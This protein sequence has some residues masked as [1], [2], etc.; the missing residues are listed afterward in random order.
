MS[1]KRKNIIYVL[2][3]LFMIQFIS[4]TSF[5]R[6]I[7]NGS[8][9]GYEEGDGTGEAPSSLASTS[10]EGFIEIGGG[11]YLET[12]EHI[13]NLSAMLESGAEQSNA[14]AGK[15]DIVN[16]ALA[17]IDNAVDSY[18]RLIE[19]AENTP[20]NLAV[21][22]KLKE[23]PYETFMTANGLND[24]TFGKVESYLKDGNITGS[25]KY[26]RSLLLEIKNKIIS[27]KDKLVQTGDINSFDLLELN[28]TLSE[29]SIFGNYIARVFY[30][31]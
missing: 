1:A 22:D 2:A 10:I 30:T 3:F 14:A 4:T 24:V 11:Y 28:E 17:S 23:F 25:Y 21:N 12:R 26:S 6:I 27:L 9:T 18:D 19:K 31:L 5:A 29:L 7:S 20:Y 15:S 13:D 8:G 16:Y